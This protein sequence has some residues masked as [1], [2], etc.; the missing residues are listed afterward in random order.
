ML[1]GMRRQAASVVALPV[2]LVMRAAPDED[3][4]RRGGAERRAVEIAERFADGK[5]RGSE[6]RR[7]L[8]EIVPANALQV[9]LLTDRD[10]FVEGTVTWIEPALDLHASARR[11]ASL[12]FDELVQFAV[13]VEVIEK[14]NTARTQH[15][16]HLAHDLQVLFLGREV[17]ETGK[18]VD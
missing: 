16:R 18:E 15:A 7:D 9:T 6:H 4:A 17:A 1:S 11:I 10:P 5:A 2:A 13:D 8:V 12:A 3:Q 14:K